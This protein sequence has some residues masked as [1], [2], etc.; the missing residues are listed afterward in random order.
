L[1]DEQTK[2]ATNYTQKKKNFHCR[3][4]SQISTSNFTSNLV[5]GLER[6]RESSWFWVKLRKI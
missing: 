4:H 3:S 6:K 1:A 2:N 5:L